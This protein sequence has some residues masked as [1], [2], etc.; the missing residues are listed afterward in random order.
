MTTRRLY[1]GQTKSERQQDRRGRLIR[2]AILL[3][4]RQGYRNTGVRAVCLEAGLTER[5][6]YESFANSEALL[7]DAFDQ[8]VGDLIDRIRAAAADSKQPPTE[9]AR[10]ML[11]EYFGAIQSDPDAARM[12][13]VEIVGVSPTTDLA[14]ERSMERLSE[15]IL[16]TFDPERIGPFA[17]E[18]LLRHG[19]AGGLLHIA[20]AWLKGGY[21]RALDEV[22]GAAMRLCLLARPDPEFAC[23]PVD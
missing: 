20:L 5:Y 22:V 16:E 3:Y 11:T 7:S 8:L 1:G 15:L 2:A 9:R 14:F 18:P 13:L 17:I 23:R 12:F 19:V 10:R 21:E 6:F 4:G